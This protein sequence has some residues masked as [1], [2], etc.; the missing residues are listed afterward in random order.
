MLH[1]DD[2]LDIDHT[3][4]YYHNVLE[5]SK[6]VLKMLLLIFR[7]AQVQRD[8]TFEIHFHLNLNTM[9]ICKCKA[10]NWKIRK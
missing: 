7:F 4:Q 8:G 3:Q 5:I 10:K 1:M 6:I 2:V 9:Y